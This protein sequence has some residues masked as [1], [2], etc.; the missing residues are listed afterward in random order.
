MADT[1]GVAGED[2]TEKKE[3]SLYGSTVA[4]SSKMGVEL[5]M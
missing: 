5:Y 3:P 2:E 1:H 4:K